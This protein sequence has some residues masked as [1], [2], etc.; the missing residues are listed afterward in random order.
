METVTRQK[1]SKHNLRIGF[2][3]RWQPS[4][5]K[6]SKLYLFHKFGSGKLTKKVTPIA[7]PMVAWN[8]KKQEIKQEYHKQYIEY[9][10]W[11]NDYEAKRPSII[12]ALSEKK[13]NHL[14]AFDQLLNIVKDGEVLDKFEDFCKI[15]KRN[16]K[17]NVI[18]ADAIDK[19]IKHIQAIQTALYDL[20]AIQYQR[21]RWSHLQLSTHHISTIE[22][23][24]A[25]HK[26]ANNETKNRYLESLNYASFVNPNTTDT[27]PFQHKY[28]VADNSQI[29]QDKYL[30]RSELSEG[31]LNIGNNTYFLEAYLFWLLSFSLRGVDGCDIAIMDKSW[32]VDE[33]GKSVD[34]KDIMHYI[35]NY[36]KLLNR[37]THETNPDLKEVLHLLPKKFKATDKKVYISGYRKKTSSKAVGIRI[38]FNHCPTLIIHRLLKYMIEV[39]RPHLVYKGDDPMKLYSF[40]YFSKEGRKQWKNLQGTYTEQL[41]KLCGINGKLKHTRHTFTQELSEIYGGNGAERLLSVS[42]GHRK[43]QL[44]ER[45]VKVPQYRSDILQ[46]EVL[47]SYSINKVLKLL[48]KYC[49]KKTYENR[50]L[51]KPLISTEGIRPIVNKYELEALEMPLSYWSW[52]KEEEYQRLMKKENDVVIDDFDDEG[53]PI[54]KKVVYSKE[55]QDLINERSEQ[56]ESKKIKR[57]SV[58]YKRSSD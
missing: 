23:L 41:K 26:G 24:L 57:E 34:P 33:K 3:D 19:H 29:E 10:Q 28:E 15:K 11:L 2:K 35:P 22:D 44:I 36:T 32:L 58:G 16:R 42:L 51:E 25:K 9:V 13:I 56:I 17:G 53:K 27:Q 55:L 50:G 31:I 47:K 39:N 6:E 12:L 38:L 5:T 40:D 8:K 7:I 49:S 43:K 1:T 37:Y 21:L 20:G 18:T 30:L 45:Y 54:R 4:S 52:R 46:V 14:Q 48:V